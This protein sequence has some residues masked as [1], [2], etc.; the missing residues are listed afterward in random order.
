MSINRIAIVSLLASALLGG[1]DA[2]A[3]AQSSCSGRSNDECD[4][5]GFEEADKELA[6]IVTA[7]LAGIDGF[8]SPETRQEAK[9]T[10]TAAHSNWVSLRALDCQSESAFS[11]LRS[12]RTR[13]GFTASCMRRLTEKRIAELKDRYLLKN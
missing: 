3:S 2:Q 5:L 11:W 13:A 1:M 12:A 4:Q 10:L 8:A 9:D 7:A 6:G